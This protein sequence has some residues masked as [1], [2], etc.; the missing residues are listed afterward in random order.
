MKAELLPLYQ[1]IIN[2][3]SHLNAHELMEQ[4]LNYD[5]DDKTIYD[6]ADK[7][8]KTNL[9]KALKRRL[10]DL[11]LYE[12]SRLIQLIAS[13]LHTDFVNHDSEEWFIAFIYKYYLQ[14]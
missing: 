4:L 8:E 5:Q 2:D 9:R 11:K 3:Q 1:A 6:H 10:K 14:G 12:F 7:H 13:V